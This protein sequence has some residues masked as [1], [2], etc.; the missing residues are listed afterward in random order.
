RK[1]V[2]GPDAAAHKK[3]LEAVYQEIKSIDEKLSKLNNQISNLSINNVKSS[4]SNE[5]LS[6]D[7]LKKKID[8]LKTDQ[9]TYNSKKTSLQNS[10]HSN[11]LELKKKIADLNNLKSGSKLYKTYNFK[12]IDQINDKIAEIQSLLDSGSLK[13]VDEKKKLKEINSLKKFKLDFNNFDSH[14]KKIDAQS[15]EI[16]ELKSA[17]TTL[18]KSY[19]INQINSQFSDY[20]SQLQSIYDSNRSSYLKKNTLIESKRSLINEKN[21]K[22]DQLSTLKKN[23]DLSYSKFLKDLKSEQKRYQ[24]KEKILVKL[25]NLFEKKKNVQNDLLIYK[26]KGLLIQNLI[27][28]FANLIN[29]KLPDDLLNNLNSNN[30]NISTINHIDDTINKNIPK[31]K[32]EMYDDLQI[33]KKDQEIFFKGSK[34]SKKNKHKNNSKNHNQNSSASSSKFTLE[35]DILLGLSELNITVPLSK[36]DCDRVIDELIQAL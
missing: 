14:Q 3:K 22:Y 5:P 23:Y 27:R 30:N 31:R 7:E 35:P 6:K 28:Y 32:I 8:K 24:S 18:N 21:T 9:N 25:S 20:K 29:K 1:Y 2:K 15:S 34:T 4:Q 19:N 16:S 33:I 13:I 36:D 11:E 10:I 17:L 12:S 26:N